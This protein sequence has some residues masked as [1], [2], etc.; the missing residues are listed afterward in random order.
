MSSRLDRELPLTRRGQAPLYL[1][2]SILLLGLAILNTMHHR[3]LPS[4]N[5]SI[6]PDQLQS[7]TLGKGHNAHTE[8]SLSSPEHVDQSTSPQTPLIQED[9]DQVK[10]KEDST[11][12]DRVSQTPQLPQST[13]DQTA[14]H[15]TAI[16]QTTSPA[17]ISIRG[18][19][20]GLD[21]FIL[22]GLSIPIKPIDISVSQSH[23][24]STSADHPQQV[25]QATSNHTGHIG[26]HQEVRQVIPSLASL[27]RYPLSDLLSRSRGSLE[28][29]A[30]RDVPKYRKFVPQLTVGYLYS[31]RAKRGFNVGFGL[32]HKLPRA[33]RLSI[34]SNLI[35]S[36]LRQDG[37]WWSSLPKRELDN[38][39]AI[40]GSDT[41]ESTTQ[42]MED[43]GSATSN[44]TITKINQIGLSLSTDYRISSRL[45]IS[46]GS[47]YIYQQ[48]KSTSN[49]TTNNHLVDSARSGDSQICM[50]L[51]MKYHLSSRL[52]LQP[53]WRIHPSR[54]SD[55]S[56]NQLGLDLSFLLGY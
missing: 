5:L 23:T 28:L 43:Y 24:P 16:H 52:S 41:E 30:Q 34:S 39:V 49:M 25:S 51:R 17:K 36:H 20:Q 29:S 21:P 47:A 27:S 8:Y 50:D 55:L 22:S 15:Q 10:Q 32:N 2:T 11:Y 7:I 31:R 12:K 46:V 42:E 35:Y 54:R 3:H 38:T 40:G 14:I 48:V 44:T 9:I 45:S 18:S 13:S 6:E 53:Y 1:V 56:I 37:Q 19:R 26:D 4:S 33:Q